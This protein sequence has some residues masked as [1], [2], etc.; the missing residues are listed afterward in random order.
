L[1]RSVALQNPSAVLIGLTLIL[2]VGCARFEPRPL[3]PAETA[4]RLESRSLTNAELRV[5]IEQNLG[6]ELT[7]WPV[8][9]WDFDKLTLAALYYSPVLEVARAQWAVARGG[10]VTAAQRPNPTLN[11]TPGYDTTTSVPSP[12][13]PLTYIDVPIETAGKRKFR[14][15][16]AAH[17]SQAARLNLA[18]VAWLVRSQLRSNLLEL[19][20]ITRRQ[21]L[22]QR[23]IG[24]QEQIVTSMNQQVQE[25]AIAA[26][27][28]LPQQIALTRTRLDL[29][30]ARRLEADARARVAA[31][32]GLPCQ[33][34]D[35]VTLRPLPEPAPEVAARLSS[36]QVRRVALESRPD[37]LGAL[38]EYAAS[39][40]ALQLEIAGQYPD[41][42]LQPGYQYD[43]GDN[44]WTLGIVV[45]LPVLNQNQGPIAQAKARRQEAAARFEALQTAVL[46]E[47]DRAVR[48]LEVT[49]T[50]MT[51]LR[52]LA[53]EQS[54][55][56]A[57]IE[58]QFKAG[59]VDRLQVMNADYE[60]VAA[61]LVQLDG[62]LRFQQAFA[63]LEDAV[64]RPFVPSAAFESSRTDAL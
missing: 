16:E 4:A 5:F 6:Y 52:A 20:A 62:Q 34:L 57:S 9:S 61:E 36:A 31:S 17:L 19:H 54:R 40:S 10:E 44:K 43:Q 55:R 38:A 32:L 22:L 14:R 25:G 47:I 28:V 50:N 58:A 27:E 3:S 11:A 48:V 26:S 30:D 24:F 51:T 64:R 29:A 56:R 39:Q 45:D 37:I 2:L 60:T 46:G 7:N 12:W 23:Q 63:A 8:G 49:E 53:Q 13:I 42:H 41:V 59:A 15:A 35:R 1:R 33:A 18:T 21:Q